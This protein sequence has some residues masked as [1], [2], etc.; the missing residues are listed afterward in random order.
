DGG[1]YRVPRNGGPAT[2]LTALPR[3]TALFKRH[4]TI[5]PVFFIAQSGS[6]GPPVIDPVFVVY[7]VTMGVLASYTWT[8][9]RPSTITGIIDLPTP[10]IQ[11]HISHADGTMGWSLNFATPTP[12]VLVPPLP[13]GGT[14]AAHSD[15]TYAQFYLLGNASHPFLKEIG[16]PG[17]TLPWQNR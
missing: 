16:L 2:L 14:T 7:D 17:P 13:S 5:S 4:D 15:T 6:A 12:Q 8:G 1:V 10:S 9:Y 3:A 11:Q